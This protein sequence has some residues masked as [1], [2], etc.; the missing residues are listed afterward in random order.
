V[1]S[2]S[3]EEDDL[4]SLHLFF[5][6]T[7]AAASQP[8]HVAGYLDRAFDGSGDSIFQPLSRIFSLA[9]VRLLFSSLFQNILLDDKIINKIK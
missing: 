8:A 2:V 5:L 1:N 4:C 3:V 9:A 7:Y 6:L